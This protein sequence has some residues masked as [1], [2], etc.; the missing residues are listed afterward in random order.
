MTLLIKL[1]SIAG[2]RSFERTAWS[3]S[4]EKEASILT[5]LGIPV[6]I[7]PVCQP[8]KLMKFV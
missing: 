1:S 6:V 4:A 2:M 7:N 3:T 5:A 8:V